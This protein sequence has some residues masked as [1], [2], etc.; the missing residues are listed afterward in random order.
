MF[1]PFFF[2]FPCRTNRLHAAPR[3]YLSRGRSLK[4]AMTAARKPHGS[5]DVQPQAKGDHTEQC[6]HVL[7]PL[8]I[9][10]EA[11]FKTLQ[12]ERTSAINGRR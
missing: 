6:M 10:S 7:Y 12:P 4:P 8:M 1:C 9:P 3:P 11:S 5:L 2:F